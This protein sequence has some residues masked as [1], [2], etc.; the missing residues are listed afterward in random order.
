MNLVAYRNRTETGSPDQPALM[1][2]REIDEMASLVDRFN[3][4]H[5]RL[6]EVELALHEDGDADR[7]MLMRRLE[8]AR[9]AYMDAR[10]ALSFHSTQH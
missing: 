7:P 4:A 3:Q 1:D 2:G 8:D 10:F 5:A 9:G 6:N